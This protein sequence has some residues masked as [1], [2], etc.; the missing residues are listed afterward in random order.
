MN[1]PLEP[2]VGLLVKLGSALVH[3]DEMREYHFS[4]Q[5]AAFPFDLAALAQTLDDPEVRAWLAEMSKL[6][7]MPVKR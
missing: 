7:L 6:G 1:N 4:P 3:M 2:S 5:H